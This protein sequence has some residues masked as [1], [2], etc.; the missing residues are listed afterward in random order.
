M[1]NIIALRIQGM[2]CGHCVA[3]VERALRTT[4][5]LSDVSVQVGRAEFA[6]AESE[7]QADVLAKAVDAIG[8]AGYEATLDDQPVTGSESRSGCCCGSA[9][10]PGTVAL[11][12]GGR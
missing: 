11:G 6:I 1:S 4:A 7:T 3:A 8:S 10:A 9:R 2:S 5:G 12:R